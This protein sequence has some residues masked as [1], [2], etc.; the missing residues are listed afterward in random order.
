MAGLGLRVFSTGSVGCVIVDLTNWCPVKRGLIC[1]CLEESGSEGWVKAQRGWEGSV[2]A[3]QSET[4]L[5]VPGHS[6]S[7]E[8]PSLSLPLSDPASP[9]VLLRYVATQQP[10]LPAPLSVF[11]LLGWLFLKESFSKWQVGGPEIMKPGFLCTQMSM[12]TC[13]RTLFATGLLLKCSIFLKALIRPPYH[14][15]RVLC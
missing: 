11:L 14:L 2:S 7:D 5:A 10:F 12:Q 13:K 1:S 3:A 4:R 8:S 6:S 15:A 9:A